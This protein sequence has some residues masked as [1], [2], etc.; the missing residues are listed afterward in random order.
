[1]IDELAG[2]GIEARCVVI[3]DDENLDT[4]RALGFDTV[5]RDNDWLGR[6]FNDGMEF[7][8]THGADWI[9]PIGSDSW[10]DADYFVPLP[11]P[12]I[13]RT[14]RMYAAVTADR[15]AELSVGK[16]G[17]GPYI[18]PAP[19]LASVGYRPA[20]DEIARRVDSST[21]AGI[22][23]RIH[24]RRRDLHPLQYIGFR[25]EPH[26][27]PYGRLFRAWG[28]AERSDPWERLAE[29]YPIDLVERARAALV[30]P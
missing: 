29:H 15:L 16:R 26:L 2:H 22:T 20:V 21:I 1:M 5:E 18:F 10:I 30:A 4:A 19:L 23:E 9:A 28:T 8:G 3:A 25:G 6:R 27:T 17:A 7:A 13:T 12:S 11:G 24:W 14:S